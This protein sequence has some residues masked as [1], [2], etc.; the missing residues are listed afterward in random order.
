MSISRRAVL[1]ASIAASL[2]VLS[3]AALSQQYPSRPLHF[4][5]PYPAGGTFDVLA[6]MLAER[7]AIGLGQPVLVENRPGASGMIA[8]SS[9]AKAEPDG[10]TFLVT[11]SSLVLNFASFKTVSYHVED[12]A[13]VAGL[14]DMPL[15]IGVNPAFPAKTFP[16][17]VATIKASPDK[18]ASSTAGTIEEIVLERLKKTAGLQFQNIPYPGAAPSLNAA[19]GGVVPMIITAAGAA[20]PMH[21]SGRLRVLAVTGGQRL[22]AMPDVPTM[23]E[24]GFAGGDLSS[25]AGLIAPRKTDPAILKRVSEEVRKAMQQPDVVAKLAALSLPVHP[26]DS[27]QFGKFIDSEF[28]KWK[29]AALEAG[30]KPE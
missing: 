7:L 24:L 1:K 23:T 15:A 27:E 9:V 30:I 19:V 17:L 4:V 8:L 21:R 16:E 22:A 26:R 14:I 11:G 28:V 13:P 6:R 10:Y 25:W 12:F 2:L 20:Q 5:V 18:Y 29:Q 3:S